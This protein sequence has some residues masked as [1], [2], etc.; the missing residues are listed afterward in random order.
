MGNG[1]KSFFFSTSSYMK[2]GSEPVMGILTLLTSSIIHSQLYAVCCHLEADVPSSLCSHDLCF[3]FCS[4]KYHPHNSLVSLCNSGKENLVLPD[5][6]HQGNNRVKLPLP[7]FWTQFPF[8]SQLKSETEIHHAH[9]RCIFRP[10]ALCVL[11]RWIRVLYCVLLLLAYSGGRN[12]V[13]PSLKNESEL[14]SFSWIKG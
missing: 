14:Q 10:G 6:C 5:S 7:H 13:V 3:L 8:Y 9:M 1:M 2:S 11:T 4:R 12:S